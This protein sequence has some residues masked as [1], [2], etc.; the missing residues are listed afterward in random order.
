MAISKIEELH[1]WGWWGWQPDDDDE[2]MDKAQ[3]SARPGCDTQ[4]L[5]SSAVI[6][7][8]IP[9]QLGHGDNPDDR[10]PFEVQP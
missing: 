8:E 9:G 5:T 7:D 10:R 2:A 4:S 6:G 1:Y 3:E